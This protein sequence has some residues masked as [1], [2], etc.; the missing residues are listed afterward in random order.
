MVGCVF[1]H[2]RFCVCVGTLR[3]CFFFLNLYIMRVRTAVVCSP[4]DAAILAVY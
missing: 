4:R 2:I 1:G 3:L